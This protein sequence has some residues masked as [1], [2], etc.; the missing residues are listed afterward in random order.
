MASPFVHLAVADLVRPHLDLAEDHLPLFLFGSVAPD[1]DKL[2]LCSREA[3]HF[4]SFSE[5]VS[6]ALKILAA[7]PHL[8]AAH[9][10]PAERAFIAGYLCHLVAD[11]QW[12][13]AI[14]RP[15]FGRHSPFGG[16]QEG[17]ELQWALHTVLEQ[18][19]LD[20]C[21]LDGDAL[22]GEAALDRPGALDEPGGLNGQ[23][24]PDARRS[25]HDLVRLLAA[26]RDRPVRPDALPFVPLR[27]LAAW[28]DNV[29]GQAPLAP[30]AERARHMHAARQALAADQI[31]DAADRARPI[32][33]AARL[34][35]LLLRLPPLLPKAAAYVPREALAE[36]E[37]RAVDA[38]VAL[39]RDFL[40]GRPLQPP[41]G[42]APPTWPAT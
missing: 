13:L 32:A 39:L 38:S 36:F 16:S 7:H 2:G 35:A 28:R 10:A 21:A 33:D 3:S 12:M 8:A 37:R 6:G 9:V 42:T 15:F 11:E 24:A 22:D 30:G 1:V 26:S 23:R 34:E 41:P 14:Y 20:G 5:D 31:G 4:W 27:H 29:L 17:V 19:L 40:A 18:R 25:I